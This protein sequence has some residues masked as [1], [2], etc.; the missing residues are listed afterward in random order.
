MISYT[1]NPKQKR[2]KMTKLQNGDKA[3]EFNLPAD[4]DKHISLADYKGKKNVVLYFYPKDN[5]P[6]CT[7]EAKDFRDLHSEFEEKDT[8]ILGVSKDSVKKHNKFKE[9]YCLPFSLIADEELDICQKYDVWKEKSLYGRKYMGIA[10][11]T[12][13]IDKEGVIKNIWQDVKVKNHAK[14]VLEKIN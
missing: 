13:L 6:G 3:P 4:D 9:K 2:G 8:V 14:D 10:R 5:T 12:F 11:T 1:K 7:M